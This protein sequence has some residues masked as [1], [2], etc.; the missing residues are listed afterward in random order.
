M[1]KKTEELMNEIIA[2]KDI[3]R[4]IGDNTEE[5]TDTPLH[6]YLKEL[7][8]DAR[9]TVSQVAELSCKGEYIYQ[10]FRGIKNPGRDVVLSIALAMGLNPDEASRLLRIARMPLLD[11]R[12]RR[13]SIIIFALNRKQT[14]PD[15]N[16]ILYE[17][18]VPCL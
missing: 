10:V 1:K 9:L 4:Y 13:D 16:D 15:T 7:L 5:F 14:V 3:S 6:V 2:S 18:D 17:F 11:A 8:S 12:N